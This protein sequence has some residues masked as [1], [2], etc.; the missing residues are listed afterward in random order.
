MY[1]Y[2]DGV[3]NN[4]NQAKEY[5]GKACDIGVQFGCDEYKSSKKIKS[6]II[7][8]KISIIRLIYFIFYQNQ[9]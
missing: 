2:G 3:E 9:R 8:Y 1:E 7:S 6:F 5:Y 4:L